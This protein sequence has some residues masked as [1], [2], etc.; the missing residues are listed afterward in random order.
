MV[1]EEN[2]EAPPSLLNLIYVLERTFTKPESE[3][4]LLRESVDRLRVSN[5]DLNLELLKLTSTAQDLVAAQC[6]PTSVETTT[7]IEAQ[8]VQD[9]ER[10]LQIGDRVRITSRQHFGIEGTIHSFT[11]QRVRIQIEG[12]CR[13]IIR[14][15]NNIQRINN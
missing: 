8:P 3:I 2:P 1:S 6:R 13:P 11:N 9:E 5:R 14:A 15:A 12:R 10:P 7:P 4:T